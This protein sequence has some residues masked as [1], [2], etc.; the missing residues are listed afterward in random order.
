[1]SWG[2]KKTKTD[3]PEETAARPT[4][5]TLEDIPP[6]ERAREEGGMGETVNHTN[7]GDEAVTGEERGLTH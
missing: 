1:M 6:A 7:E 3:G 5:I 4:T 2:L